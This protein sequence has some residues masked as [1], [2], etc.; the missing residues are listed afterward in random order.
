MF[1]ALLVV[2]KSDAI[3]AVELTT[4]IKTRNLVVAV[5]DNSELRDSC[6]VTKTI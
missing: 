4:R 1:N 6:L 2:A 3:A 5:L